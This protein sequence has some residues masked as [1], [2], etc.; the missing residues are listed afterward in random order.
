MM[1]K[2][3][4]ILLFS[5][6]SFFSCKEQ[7]E[8][9]SKRNNL[10]EAFNDYWYAGKAEIASYKLKQA[11]Y[12]EIHD[13]HAVLIFVTEDFSREKH[14]KLDNPQQAEEDRVKVMKLNFMKNFNTGIYP[15]SIMM[16]VFSPVYEDVAP[17]KLSMSSQEWCGHVFTQMNNNDQSYDIRQFSYF[18]SEGDRDYSIEAGFTEDEIWNRIRL[19]YQSL[20]EG[21]ITIIPGLIMTR[22]LHKELEPV[23]AVAELKSSADTLVY[24]VKYQDDH[25]LRIKFSKD[26]PHHIYGWEEE[27]IGIDGRQLTTSAQLMDTMAIDYWTKNKTKYTYLRDSLNLK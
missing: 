2:K 18:E 4:L 10:P 13:G 23:S 3:H 16:S 11:R 22:L 12:G 15:Y 19:D 25:A 21:E 27:L 17:L 1:M 9:Q 7:S 24:N 5:L 6:A 14:V 26:F 20:P 8:D